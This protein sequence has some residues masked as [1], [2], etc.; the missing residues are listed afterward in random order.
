M[1]IDN[2]IERWGLFSV[3]EERRGRDREAERFFCARLLLCSPSSVLAFFCARL[4]TA[5]GGG[6]GGKVSCAFL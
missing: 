4:A 2:V 3:F 1:D 6:A 5:S